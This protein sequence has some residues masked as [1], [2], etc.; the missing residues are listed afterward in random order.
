M[1]GRFHT[2]ISLASALEKQATRNRGYA[3]KPMD[4]A[5]TVYLATV[6]A[7]PAAG[8]GFS[9][10]ALVAEADI[11][12][13]LV[14]FGLIGMSVTCWAIILNKFITVR[15]AASQSRRFVDA[16]WKASALEQAYQA[17]GRYPRSPTAE[18]FKAGYVELAKLTQQ[19]GGGS[20]DMG[21]TE[22]VE[23]ALRRTAQVQLNQLERMMA[24]LATTASTG[25]FIGLFGTV[26][27]ILN[28]LTAIGLAGQASIDKV[29]GPVGAALIMTAIGL[30]VAV[31][32]VMGYNWLLNRN[33]ACMAQ[34]RAFAGDLHGVLMGSRQIKR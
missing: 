11:V 3:G 15:S 23:R 17:S 18:V 25:P 28:A 7:A 16:F 9:V 20:M 14:L 34:V 4:S 24:F 10:F 22:N 19:D 5:L 13:Q 30:A 2:P 21:L 8:D 31:P 26:W 33:K 27:G 29:A 1:R 32:A 6:G 12:V